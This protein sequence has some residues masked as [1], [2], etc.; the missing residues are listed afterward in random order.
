MKRTLSMI[1]ALLLIAAVPALAGWDEGVAA[2]TKKDY[3]TAYQQFQEYVQSNPEAFQGQ[4]MLGLAASKLGRKEES[5]QHL[6]KAYDLNPND[7]SIKMALAGAYAANKRYGDVTTLLNSVD[8]SK[9]PAAQQTWFYQ[10]RA[11]ALSKTGNGE[12]ALG[13]LAK[14]AKMK[15]DDAG[16]Q[17]SYGTTAISAGQT[18]SGLAALRKSTQLDAKNKDYRKTYTN[19][20]IVKGRQTRDKTAKKQAYQQAATEAKALVAL[21]PSYDNV[22]LQASAELGA[23]QYDAAA[24]TAQKALAKNGND[25]LGHFYLGQ[26]YTSNG[27]YA[28][29]EGALAKAQ[30]L[31]RKSSDKSMVDKQLA[32]AY[33]KQKKYAEAI[34]IYDSVGDQAAANRV[35]ENVRIAEENKNIE[36]ENA[37]IKEMEAEAKALEEQ[38]KELEG[39]G[40]L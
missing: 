37:R 35:R 10:T 13:D 26:A 23:Q 14:L 28:K 20:L 40:G 17:Y 18:D 34:R 12:S 6:R 21:D 33:E 39:G 29:A 25:W 22:L 4:Y 7:L 11:T 2:F 15:P 9:L 38:L 36:E 5:L 24:A 16:I 31:A 27:Q 19:A 3:Q 1:V 30:S 8:P 32:F